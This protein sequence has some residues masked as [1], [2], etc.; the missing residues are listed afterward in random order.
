MNKYFV[1]AISYDKLIY[2]KL[3]LQNQAKQSTEAWA[4]CHEWAIQPWSYM[5][6]VSDELHPSWWLD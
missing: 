3:I 6:L 1:I 5:L 2:E 4:R